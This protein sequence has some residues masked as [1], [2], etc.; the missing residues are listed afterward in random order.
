MTN[1]SMQATSR[2]MYVRREDP[3]GQA[4]TVITEHLV[5]DQERFIRSEQTRC[6]EEPRNKGKHDEVRIITPATR[7]DYINDRKGSRK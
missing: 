2:F 5:W 3:K 4:A 1:S 7:A 6:T